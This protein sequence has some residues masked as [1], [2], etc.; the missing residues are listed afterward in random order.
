MDA[1]HDLVNQLQIQRLEEVL[2]N[3]KIR[4]SKIDAIIS[5]VERDIVT[6]SKAVI[7]HR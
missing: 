7:T 4:P 3:L 6:A 2:F 1:Y 5:E